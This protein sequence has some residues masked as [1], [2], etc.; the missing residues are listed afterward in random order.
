M[1]LLSKLVGAAVV[2][3]TVSACSSI[4]GIYYIFDICQWFSAPPEPQTP[5]PATPVTVFEDPSTIVVYHGFSCADSPASGGKSVRIP[6]S[7][8]LPGYASRATVFLNGWRLRFL[9]GDRHV[10]AAGAILRGVTR[11][12]NELRWEAIGAIA[13]DRFDE[14]FNFCYYYTVAGWSGALDATVDHSDGRCYTNEAQPDVEGNFYV[15]N[16][17]SH[18]T[19]LSCVPSFGRNPA[20]EAVPAGV[21][22]RGFGFAFDGGDSHVLQIAATFDHSERF[23]R[24]GQNY[25]K[26]FKDVVP[27]PAA[28]VP[29]PLFSHAGS[30]FVSWES[31]GILKD[32][33]FRRP[34][35]FG[36]MNSIVAGADVGIIEPPFSI[37]PR[38]DLGLFT[39]C[40]DAPP[41]ATQ[42]EFAIDNIP[43]V[44]AIPMLSGWD[45]SYLCGDAHVRELGVGLS[46]FRYDVFGGGR[47]L[48]Y[49]LFSILSDDSGTASIARHK[50]SVLG[51][52]PSPVVGPILKPAPTEVQR[53]QP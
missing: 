22:P 17:E 24:G 27:A 6:Q 15:A 19:A 47:T 41:D 48:Y 31:Y 29:E 34:Y 12:R 13:D 28:S 45:L 39:A 36:Q 26:R 7:L 52:R 21:M 23:I 1:R 32:N 20:G 46:E 16:N 51:L 25:R 43:Y 37:L 44:Y 35:Y 38:E 10:V 30:G 33:D 8:Q 40:V 50:V 42:T 3:L 14:A 18:T 49:K 2:L 5:V 4:L 53:P 9:D 11:E